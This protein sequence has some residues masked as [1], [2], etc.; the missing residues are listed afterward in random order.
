MNNGISTAVLVT[1]L[2]RGDGPF[3]SIADD[4]VA[5]MCGFCGKPVDA[6]ARF[7]TDGF[8]CSACASVL[9]IVSK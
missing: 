1:D 8:V 5:M 6:D 3:S 4:F 2:F 9:S 7:T